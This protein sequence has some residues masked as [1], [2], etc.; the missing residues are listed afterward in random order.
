MGACE[1]SGIRFQMV[2]FHHGQFST[3][4]NPNWQDNP[5]N[6]AKGGFL[7]D[8]ADFFTDKQSKDLAKKWLRYAVAR[9]AASPNVL[10]WEL[11]NEVEWVDARYNDRW[12]DVEDWHK[13]MADYVRSI[14]PYKHLITTSS[15]QRPGLLK[16][17]DYAQPHVYP[18]N[19]KLAIG[20]F[21]VNNDKA[22]FFGEFGPSDLD[23]DDSRAGATGR[24]LCWNAGEPCGHR[25]VLAVGCH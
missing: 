8:P 22:T 2:L 6:Q 5:I 19:L 7:K 13:E 15:D 4:V 14:D 21:P 16:S 10:A 12:K 18:P 3:K 20:G 9:Y 17:V 11:F 25:H 23:K 1:K 24:A